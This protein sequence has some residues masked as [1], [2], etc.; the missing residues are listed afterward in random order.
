MGKVKEKDEVSTFVLTQDQV[1]Q[2]QTAIKNITAGYKKIEGGYLSIAKDVAIIKQNESYIH[3]GYKSIS[4]AMRGLFG[5]S[6][7]TTSNLLAIS[8]RFGAPGTFELLPGYQK[9]SMKA[10]LAIAPL[11]PD[12]EAKLPQGWQKW[13][14]SDLKKIVKE[15]KGLPDKSATSAEK[16]DNAVYG[17]DSGNEEIKESTSGLT[18]FSNV[19]MTEEIWESDEALAEMVRKWM[20]QFEEQG[21]LFGAQLL[22]TVAE[23]D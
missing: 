2:H 7:Q 18:T 17:D 4:A 1:L 20:E 8:Y 3:D 6:K 21:K 11:T 13:T 9:A 10:L 14:E 19:T 5:M 12:E 15:I 22:V 23:Y 16:E